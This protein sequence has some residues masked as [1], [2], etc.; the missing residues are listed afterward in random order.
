MSEEDVVVTQL[1]KMDK[2]MHRLKYRTHCKKTW[3]NGKCTS[4]DGSIDAMK[5]PVVQVE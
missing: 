1:R 3:G 4:I 2:V 5:R